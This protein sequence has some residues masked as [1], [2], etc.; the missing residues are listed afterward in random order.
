LEIRNRRKYP[1]PK[2]WEV[3]VTTFQT[4]PLHR[5]AAFREGGPEILEVEFLV[6]TAENERPLSLLPADQVRALPRE[7]EGTRLPVVPVVSADDDLHDSVRALTSLLLDRQELAGAVVIRDGEVRGVLPRYLI[8]QQANLLNVS[9]F[10]LPGYPGIPP[11]VYA[12]PRGDYE[13]KVTDYNP[14]DPPRCPQ[15]GDLLVR[16]V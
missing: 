3:M 9:S 5:V 2:V 14:Y 12:C 11:P 13:E 7:G 4:E 1:M 6:V 8:A 16:K 15:H 10:G